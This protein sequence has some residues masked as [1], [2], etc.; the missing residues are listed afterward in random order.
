MTF[1]IVTIDKKNTNT[2]N[3]Y[4]R[5][6]LGHFCDIKFTLDLCK[7]KSRVYWYR[8]TIN[9]TLYIR[10]SW[11]EIKCIL[12]NKALLRNSYLHINEEITR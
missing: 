5:Y 7:H 4:V 2:G 8:L 1:K 11:K 9:K 3:Y 12:I 6:M 10:D